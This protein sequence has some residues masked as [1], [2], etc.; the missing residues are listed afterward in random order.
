MKN[1]EIQ[2]ALRGS[3]DPKIINILQYLNTEIK[4]NRK[5]LLELS[6]LMDQVTG[7]VTNFATVSENMKNSME[8]LGKRMGV[9]VKSED[10]IN[11]KTE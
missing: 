10:I 9:E 8:K 4:E 5:A 1:A 7:I 3:V 6:Q 2:T 11:G